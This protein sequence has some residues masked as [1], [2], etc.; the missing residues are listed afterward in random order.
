M[1][2]FNVG[3]DNFEMNVDEADSVIVQRHFS[4]HTER[5]IEIH[6]LTIPLKP[7]WLNFTVRLIRFYQKNISDRLGNRCVFDPSCSHYAEQAYRQKGFLIGTK[8]T[9]KRLKK[10]NPKNGGIDEIKN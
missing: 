4:K 1:K 7:I 6:S 5:D 9:I 10:C 3:N 8:L 2:Q